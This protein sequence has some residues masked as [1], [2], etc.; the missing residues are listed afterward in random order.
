MG[1]AATAWSAYSKGASVTLSGSNLIATVSSGTGSVQATNKISG[2]T[3]FEL[4]I[5]ATLTGSARVGLANP[6]MTMTGLL[7]VNNNGIGYDSGGT[8][9]INNATVATIAAYVANDNIGVAVD[10][11]NKLIWFRK[12][13][14][15][16]NNDVI[17]NQNPVG[18]V[19]G[20][21][22]A[23]VNAPSSPAWGGSATSSVTAQFAS[24]SWTYT[25][26]SGFASPDTLGASAFNGSV[27]SRSVSYTQYGSAWGTSPPSPSQTSSTQ[28]SRG[29]VIKGAWYGNSRVWSPA[30]TQTNVSGQTQ[31]NGV[32]TSGLRVGLFDHTTFELLGTAVS[33]GSA[34]FSIPALGR[35][36]VFAVCL[37]DPTYNAL[38]YDSVVP[39]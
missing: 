4:V 6:I 30:A 13:G 20:I 11:I 39:A 38:I 17:A 19:G 3:Y 25:A 9:K 24:A 12:N 1:I 34:N 29:S 21:S 26:P 8:V 23:T 27:A 22:Y 37:D 33:D 5:G 18:A 35:A 36:K 16:W 10:P 7:G 28:A 15:N 32:P 14:G 2:P 31:V